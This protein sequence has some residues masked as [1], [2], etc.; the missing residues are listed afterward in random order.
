MQS[1]N[2]PNVTIRQLP[3]TPLFECQ[4]A[5]TTASPTVKN[6]ESREGLGEDEALNIEELVKDIVPEKRPP[7]SASDGQRS[8]TQ[9]SVDAKIKEVV[10]KIQEI[11]AGNASRSKTPKFA[12]LSL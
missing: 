6:Q 1:F 12:E 8:P 4:H 3:K 5:A 11:V 7:A 9:G 2:Y 10:D